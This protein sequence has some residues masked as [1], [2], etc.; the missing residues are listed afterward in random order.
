MIKCEEVL[1]ELANYIDE[2]VTAELRAQIEAHLRM[3]RNCT[4]LVNTTRRTLTVVADN[5]I[6]PLPKSISDRLIERLGLHS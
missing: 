3:C 5:F 1:A 2:E 6:A 4:V